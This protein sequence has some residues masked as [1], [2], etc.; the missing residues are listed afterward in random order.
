MWILGLHIGSLHRDTD[1]AHRMHSNFDSAAALLHDGVVVAA[2]RESTLA[3]VARD[4]RFPVR[5]IRF[6]LDSAGRSLHNIDAVALDQDESTLDTIALQRSLDNARE[7][8]RSGRAWIA[9]LFAASFDADIAG[10]LRFVDHTTSHLRAAFVDSGFERAISLCLDGAGAVAL[11][12]VAEQDAAG[13][14][15][16]KRIAPGYSMAD[17]IDTVAESC[18]FGETHAGDLGAVAAG[19]DPTRYY[20]VLGK[21]HAIAPGGELY[22]RERVERLHLLR[23]SGVLQALAL[24]N[25]AERAVIQNDIAAATQVV[26]G[27]LVEHVVRE[28]WRLSACRDLCVA[29][30]IAKDAYLV[31]RIMRAA[32]FDRLWVAPMPDD[33]GN[34]IGAAAHVTGSAVP[35]MASQMRWGR[36]LAKVDVAQRITSWGALVVSERITDPAM[37]VAHQ[38]ARGKTIAWLQGS[39]EWHARDLSS[40]IILS[41]PRLVGEGARGAVVCVRRASIAAHFECADTVRLPHN[42][43][44]CLAPRSGAAFIPASLRNHDGSVTLHAV[45]TADGQL[46]NALEAFEHLTGVPCVC[47]RAF[48]GLGG[49]LVNSLDG[50]IACLLAQPIDALMVGDFLVQR[51]TPAQAVAGVLADFVPRL[52]PGHELVRATPDGENA[53]YAIVRYREVESEARGAPISLTISRDAFD[54]LRR[55]DAQAPMRD[56]LSPLALDT[57]AL[58]ALYEE[59]IA[60]WRAGFVELRPPIVA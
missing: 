9:S 60:S 35:Y 36:D 12:V 17:L 31:G 49:T 40:R 57:A 10:R 26:L 54:V 25:T 1:I 27:D 41:D 45:D 28:A 15:V 18:A 52:A 39:A 32:V 19:G 8:M 29:G 11:A 7:P 23:D 14:R 38:L 34:A 58:A 43:N 48:I 24:A 4:K 6:C 22:L 33:A 53:E 13:V 20:E 42:A 59:V 3:G 47:G 37:V 46:H 21:M 30:E 16:L 5:A 51:R 55:H 50:A 2:C 56:A 44:C